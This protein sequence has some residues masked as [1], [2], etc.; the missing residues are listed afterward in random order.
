MVLVG[1]YDLTNEQIDRSSV[2]AQE[3]LPNYVLAKIWNWALLAAL[4]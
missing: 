4:L 1:K 2:F 3:S